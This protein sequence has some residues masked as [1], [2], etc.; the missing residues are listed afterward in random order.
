MILIL[1][2]FLG[3]NGVWFAQPTAD[4]IAS[5]ITAIV[6][7]KEIRSYKEDN[8]KAKELEVEAI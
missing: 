7:I 8:N 1:P 2:K 6:L 4:I 3:L 5:A